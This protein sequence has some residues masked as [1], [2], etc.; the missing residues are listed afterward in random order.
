[1]EELRGLLSA[2]TPEGARLHLV[3]SD[4]A[5]YVLVAPPGWR[6]RSAPATVVDADGQVV[7]RAGDEVEVRGRRSTGLAST[8][9]VGPVFEFTKMRAVTGREAASE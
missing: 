4:G 2:D 5:R 9:Q 7:A 8:Q 1:M 6:V 3:T